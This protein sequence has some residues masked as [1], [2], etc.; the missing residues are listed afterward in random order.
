MEPI[1]SPW[2]I[3]LAN[4]LSNLHDLAVAVSAFLGT[5]YIF[6]LLISY[7]ECINS[8]KLIKFIKFGGIALV[9]CIL[10]IILIPSKEIIIAML[11]VSFITPD[12]VMVAENHIVEI[13]T[14]IMNAVSTVK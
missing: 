1:I 10:L 5:V 4:V 3:Y 14:K 12:N 8:G 9:I 2:I 6:A 13:V 7:T 11:T